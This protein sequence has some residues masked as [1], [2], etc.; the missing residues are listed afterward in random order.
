ML[1]LHQSRQVRKRFR[2]CSIS[3]PSVAAATQAGRHLGDLLVKE[4]A[5]MNMPPDQQAEQKEALADLVKQL[6]K[7]ERRL[8]ERLQK[9]QTARAKAVERLN[10]AQARLQKRTARLQRLEERLSLLRRQLEALTVPTPGEPAAA[11]PAAARRE[12]APASSVAPASEAAGQPETAPPP[13]PVEL[14]TLSGLLAEEAAREEQ[15]RQALLASEA[16]QPLEATFL[17]TEGEPAWVDYLLADEAEHATQA[18]TQEKELSAQ[19]QQGQPDDVAVETDSLPAFQ[20]RL[21][22]AVLYGF[23]EPPELPEAVATPLSEP[24]PE[25]LQTS[26]LPATP[27]ELVREARA[28]AEAAEEAARLAIARATLAAAR[29]EQLPAG[30]HLSQE[31]SEAEQ[32]AAQA[33]RAAQLAEETAREVERW[34]QAVT[35]AEEAVVSS[36]TADLSTA[37]TAADDETQPVIPEDLP[38]SPEETSG[39]RSFET[40]TAL[41][42]AAASEEVQKPA[43]GDAAPTGD[44]PARPATDPAPEPPADQ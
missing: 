37:E 40:A 1:A 32:E 8:L 16:A 26:L 10:R 25:A 34:A 30:R 29:L 13:T 9:A 21:P 41:A 6:R 3:I 43:Q 24:M 36:G 28:A 19:E 35:S 42:A 39:D 33:S 2:L 27:A 11:P 44:E 18:A 14:D 23:D 22:Q 12:G 31:L 38:A 7:R 15:L 20:E 17:P 4:R 5:M